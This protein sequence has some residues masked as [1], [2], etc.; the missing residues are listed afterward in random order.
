MRRERAI[1]KRN[2]RTYQQLQQ[3]TDARATPHTIAK[4][5]KIKNDTLIHPSQQI[6]RKKTKNANDSNLGGG[7][8]ARGRLHTCTGA[9]KQNGERKTD[10]ANAIAGA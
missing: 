4:S 1:S 5:K 7:T 10:N 9:I 3:P 8:F 2:D 6:E